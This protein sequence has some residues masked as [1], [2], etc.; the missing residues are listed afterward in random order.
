MKYNFKYLP[1]IVLLSMQFTPLAAIGTVISS[2]Y[3]FLKI[4]F[5]YKLD[6]FCLFLLLL[7]TIALNQNDIL[8]QIGQNKMGES[9]WINFFIPSLKDVVMIG[10][11]A[12]STRLFA[13][14]AVPVRL[15]L[16]RKQVKVG[17]FI[18]WA[19]AFVISIYG[20]YLSA[21]LGLT[22][23]GGITVGLRITLS[24]GVLLFPAVIEKRELS[25]QLS[26]VIKLSIILFLFGALNNHWLFVSIVFP[27]V[28]LFSDEKPFWKLLSIIMIGIIVFFPSSFTIKLSLLLS[29]CL[30]WYYSPKKHK[31]YEHFRLRIKPIVLVAYLFFPIYI[32]LLTISQKIMPIAQAIGSERF[33]FKLFDDRG[34]IWMFTLD[35]IRKSNFFIVPSG[36]DIYTFNYNSAGESEWGAGAHNI[37]LEI[38]RQNGTLVFLIIFIMIIVLFRNL[39]KTTFFYDKLQL[40]LIV[41]FIAVYMVYGLTGNSLIYDGVGFMFWLIFS[42]VIKSSKNVSN[43]NSPHV[44][45]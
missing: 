16:F 3:I 13:A 40:N 19:F 9:G 6:I 8:F 11:L 17:H 37:F 45:C 43:E 7:P 29:I 44:C 38:A 42:Q 10:P 39:C 22:S 41:G 27:V 14:L 28:L 12:L 35:L 25:N 4:G 5:S 33:L 34:S 30:V 2:L 32:V 31:F 18:L 26:A 15:V 24:M 1:E 20:L 21:S 23:E 36:R